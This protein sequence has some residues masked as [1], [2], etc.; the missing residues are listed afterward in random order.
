MIKDNEYKFDVF[1]SHNNKDKRAVEYIAQRLKKKGKKVWLDKWNLVPG[2]PWQEEIEEALD[3]C[4]TFAVFLGASGIGP[5]ENEEMR[6]AIAARVRDKHRRVIPVLLPGAPDNKNL[7]LPA[8]LARLTW[9]DFR[10]GLDDENAFHNLISGIQGTPPGV[11]TTTPCR[12]SFVNRQ[13]EIDELTATTISKTPGQYFIVHAPAG[14][15]KTDLLTELDKRFSQ[16]EGWKPARAVIAKSDTLQDIA[17]QLAVSLEIDLNGGS[18][19]GW[20]ELLGGALIQKF[21][22][23]NPPEGL[24]LLIDLDQELSS[25]LVRGLLDEFIPQVWASLTNLRAFSSQQ[26]RFRVIVAGRNLANTDAVKQTSLAI[27]KRPLKPFTFDVIKTSAAEFLCNF[28]PSKIDNFA[29]DVLFLTGGHPGAMAHCFNFVQQQGFPLAQLMQY[30]DD[31]WND[32]LYRV[33]EHDYQMLAVADVKSV[34]DPLCVWRYSDDFVLQKLLG[35]HK[36]ESVRDEYDLRDKLAQTNI[37]EIKGRYLK[38]DINRRL[39]V[40]RLRKTQAIQYQIY[41]NEARTICEKHLKEPDLQSPERWMIEYL[42]QSLQMNVDGYAISD[43]ARATLSQKFKKDVT[44]S[45][46]LYLCRPSTKTAAQ[47]KQ[48]IHILF[49]KMD[50]EDQWEFPF[51]VNYLLR[52]HDY[53]ETPYNQLRDQILQLSV[54]MK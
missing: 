16:K 43:H 13:D 42:F 27:N 22:N 24:V 47:R 35:K 34:I 38:D 28:E 29:A 17:S 26:S 51:L 37:F 52:E 6:E 25:D 33:C 12:V 45:L 10:N 53:N 19:K 44:K 54:G 46:K 9:V 23:N 21:R 3:Q 32:Y 50:E 5:W 11:A 49:D 40:I 8:F 4:G 48:A 15:G 41:T 2:N 39:L 14:Y 20:G 36:V 1:L 30:G 31:I 18:N 7:K